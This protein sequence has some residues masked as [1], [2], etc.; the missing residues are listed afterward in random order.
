MTYDGKPEPDTSA[1]T[2]IIG[3]LIFAISPVGLIHSI[4]AIFG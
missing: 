1:P 2:E 3:T 4:P